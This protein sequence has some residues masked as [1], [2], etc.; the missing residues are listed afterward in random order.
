MQR[1]SNFGLA[2]AALTFQTFCYASSP[3]TE[4]DLK[5]P[6]ALEREAVAFVG[7]RA[8]SEWMPF[9]PSRLGVESASLMYGPPETLSESKP[10]SVK[11][12]KLKDIA[13]WDFSEV[14]QVEKWLSCGYGA[15]RELTLSKAF[16]R[17]VS[18]CTVTI[19][20][21]EQGWVIGI[22]AQCDKLRDKR[23]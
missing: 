9:M 1:I 15:K 12:G 10:D 22:A 5:C 23:P 2:G 8:P 21:N 7:S 13:T 6:P 19:T 3:P 11:K 14:P 18:K 16:P 17:D 4:Y 20:K